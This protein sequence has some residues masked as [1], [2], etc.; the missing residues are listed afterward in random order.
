MEKLEKILRFAI[1][2]KAVTLHDLDL[3]WAA[4]VSDN[5]ICYFGKMRKTHIVHIR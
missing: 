2:E 4:Q 3:I 1:K 5:S